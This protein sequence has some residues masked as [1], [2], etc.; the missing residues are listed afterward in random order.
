MVRF[1]V[2]LFKSSYWEGLMDWIKKHLL[3]EGMISAE[4]MKLFRIVDTP[5]EAVGHIEKFYEKYDI[6]PNF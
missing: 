2:V 5:E 3:D 4:D 1:P 6:K